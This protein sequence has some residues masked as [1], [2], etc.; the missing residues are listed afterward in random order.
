MN[1]N[2]SHCLVVAEVEVEGADEAGGIAGG[3]VAEQL[4]VGAVGVDGYGLRGIEELVG[5][6][7][8]ELGVV[9][10]CYTL[11]H[12]YVYILFLS[13]IFRNFAC[14]NP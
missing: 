10:N 4:E 9:A 13:D 5:V 7:E 1:R 14:E 11:Y 8:V 12:Y 2:D 3:E 6:A